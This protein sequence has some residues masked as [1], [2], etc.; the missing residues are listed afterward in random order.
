ML[1][2]GASQQDIPIEPPR[3]AIVLEITSELTLDG[4][5]EEPAWNTA[6]NI[7]ELMQREPRTGE[8]PSEKTDVML[9]RDANNLYIG[10]MCYDS[11][12]DKVIGTQMERDADLTRSDDRIT[13]V[14][15]T[16]RDQR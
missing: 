2:S 16:F 10:V 8:N 12:P 5:L 7:G 3:S 4:L 13:I 1:C 9:L 15:D 11:E 14:L 6:A